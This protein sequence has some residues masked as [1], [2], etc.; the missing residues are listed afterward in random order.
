[1]TN[2]RKCGV[3]LATAGLLYGTAI[4]SALAGT[5]TVMTTETNPD[6][7]TAFTNIADEYH[8]A[9]PD[10][11]I[12]FQYVGFQDLNQKMMQAVAA[13][14]PP[15]LITIGNQY[16]VFQLADQG[17]I[18]PVDDV[19][20]M[21]GRDD[22][23]PRALKADTKDGKIWAVPF[24][25]GVNVLWYRKDLYEANGLSEARNWDE[26]LANVKALD[27]AGNSAPGGKVYGTALATGDNWLTN[28]NTQN[29]MWSN[30][31]TVYDANGN[32]TLGSVD[33]VATFKYLAKLAEFAPPG[34]NSYTNSEMQNA[35]ATGAVAHT[36]YPFRLLSQLQR[37]NPD[38][39]NTAMPMLHP[40]GPG[41]SA[42]PAAFLYIK[43]WVMTQGSKN[44]E[45]AAK[46]LKFIET[47][48]AKIDV[49]KTVPVHYWPP[50][51]SVASDPNFLNQQL[52][53]T[54]AGKRSVEVL[55]KALEVGQLSITETGT[56]VLKLGPVLSKRVLASTL[57]KIVVGG[58]D[59]TKAV[60]AAASGLK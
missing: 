36:E 43:S 27:K 58:E 47:G 32:P 40:P 29:W 33:S 46:F 34:S 23:Y 1:M 53:Q 4:S 5:V 31:A 8:Q 20:D 18:R 6:T 28:D 2:C 19:I 39:L 7:Q 24:S 56:P 26:Y 22:Y 21:I 41:K 35:F 3:I 55:N 38:L 17:V 42:H 52:L 49:M 57:E 60:E 25:I 50:M 59:P 11:T 16:D 15:E 9:N 10:T 30:G 44:Q 48:Q 13:G 54:P 14:A 51:R 37:T 45:G 12:K